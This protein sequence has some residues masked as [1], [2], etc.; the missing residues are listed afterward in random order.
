ME[1]YVG[2]RSHTPREAADI[3]AAESWDKPRKVRNFAA[4]GNGDFA[5]FQVVDGLA[6]YYVEW[7]PGRGQYL[8]RQI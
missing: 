8:V 1:T 2:N 7:T 6:V 4:W 5:T 3:F